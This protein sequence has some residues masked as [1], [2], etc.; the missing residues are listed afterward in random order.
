MLPTP[1]L[2]PTN[3]ELPMADRDDDVILGF[4]LV[5]NTTDDDKD[6]D[7]WWKVTI[8]NRVTGEV[9]LVQDDIGKH[10]TWPDP[11]TTKKPIPTAG[12]IADK[13]LHFEE[14]LKFSVHIQQIREDD[15][16][17]HGWVGNFDMSAYVGGWDTLLPVVQNSGELKWGKRGQPYEGDFPFDV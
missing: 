4:L 3:G 14:R 6:D 12:S 1:Q 8:T 13:G 2:T 7:M 15:H 11:S 9:I 17:K 16:V 10:E 5:V